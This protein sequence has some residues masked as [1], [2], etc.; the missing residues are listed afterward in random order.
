M[1]RG[2]PEK[3]L[4]KQS[5]GVDR[6]CFCFFLAEIFRFS[7]SLL[8]LLLPLLHPLAETVN[9]STSLGLAAFDLLVDTGYI[10][11][12]PDRLFWPQ[13]DGGDSPWDPSKH[14]ALRVFCGRLEQ[15]LLAEMSGSEGRRPIEHA[16]AEK[17][18]HP[19]PIP[20]ARRS[21]LFRRVRRLC[22]MRKCFRA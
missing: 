3:V 16:E 15:L 6:D 7:S 1:F 11:K 12:S 17:D 8:L 18:E 20:Q 9:M 13:C 2:E 22:S 19:D 14:Q 4:Y 5:A 10:L 21:T